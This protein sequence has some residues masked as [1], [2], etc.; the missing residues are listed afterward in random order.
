MKKY[1]Q[2]DEIEKEILKCLDDGMTNIHEMYDKILEAND[3]PRPTL[4]RVK[5]GM[6]NKYKNYV[7]VLS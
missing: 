7:K 2:A 4:R 6:L 1:N 3:Y 5:S